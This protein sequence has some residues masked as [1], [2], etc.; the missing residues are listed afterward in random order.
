MKNIKQSVLV[1][2]ALLCLVQAS[3]QDEK[4]GRLE[5]ITEKSGVLLKKEFHLVGKVKNIEV[6]VVTVTNLTN[7]DVI[8]VVKLE[9][10]FYSMGSRSTTKAGVLDKDELDGIVTAMNT[11]VQQTGEAGEDYT[12]IG[13][14]ARDKGVTV[15]GFKSKGGWSYAVELGRFSS[16]TAF[17]DAKAFL[18]LALLLKQCKELM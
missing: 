17:F 6:K 13:F 18:E 2:L 15:T 12:E 9:G 7:N 8:K 1:M 16:E 10:E 11:I 4:K 5:E 14:T 3:A